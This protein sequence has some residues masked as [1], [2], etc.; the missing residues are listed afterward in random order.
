MTHPFVVDMLALVIFG[1]YYTKQMA[2]ALFE[3]VGCLLSYDKKWKFKGF[4][5]SHEEKIRMHC[6]ES[7]GKF[8]NT[9]QKVEKQESYMQSMANKIDT[10]A[11]FGITNNFYEREIEKVLFWILKVENI[12]GDSILTLR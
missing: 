11:I 12:F 10:K 3:P 9:K 7:Y 8:T 2:S 5:D 4:W 1:K 6:V